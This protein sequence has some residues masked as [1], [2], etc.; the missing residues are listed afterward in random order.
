MQP[1]IVSIR[2]NVDL[3]KLPGKDI[4]VVGTAHIS[5]AS[6]DLA[7]DVI[8]EVRPDCVAIEL[9]DSR[10]Q[11]LKD[12]D[13]WK[14]TDL[15]SIIRGGKAYVLMAQLMLSGFQRKLGKKLNIKP[16]AEMMLAASIAGELNVPVV[17][18]DR[19]IRTTLK[20]TWSGLGF[21]GLIKLCG[22]MVSGLFSKEEISADEI[23][24]LKSADALNELMREF[25][26]KLPSVRRTLIDERDQYLTQKI[27]TAPGSKIVAVV[28]AGHVPGMK[29]AFG[30][31]IDLAPLELIPPKKLSSQIFGWLLP[32]AVIAMLIYGC[33][34]ADTSTSADMIGMWFWINGLFAALGSALSL[35][36]PLTILSVFFAAPFTALHPF[37]ASGWVA[38]LVEAMLRKPLV[39]DLETI[40][41]DVST[42]RGLW[43]NRVS[44]ILLV[45]GLTNLFGTV[46]AI[47]GASSIASL[48]KG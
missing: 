24:R 7:A 46:G 6:A 13:R 37:I 47:I 14:K 5:Q 32:I 41:D 31:Q 20:R 28:G 16:G 40:A 48:L 1:E 38:G 21:I 10:F 36:H 34:A 22:A 42:L 45:V 33:F 25:S 30:T 23:E 2:P 19:D 18:A 8:R 35:G 26:A 3:V 15:V 4:Y 27:Q 11:S 9:C 39:S 43:H 17:L 44:R 29:A 12:P